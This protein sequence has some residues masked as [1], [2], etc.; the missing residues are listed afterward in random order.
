MARLIR[1]MEGLLFLKNTEPYHKLGQELK[2][3]VSKSLEVTYVT[4]D[5]AHIIKLINIIKEMISK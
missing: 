4:A 3:K 2:L 5:N 1:E